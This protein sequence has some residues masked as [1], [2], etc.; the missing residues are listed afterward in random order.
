[1]VT[2]AEKAIKRT[3][4]GIATYRATIENNKFLPAKSH[5][6]RTFIKRLFLFYYIKIKNFY[7]VKH[8]VNNYSL[9]RRIFRLA[10]TQ[11]TSA[12]YRFIMSVNGWDPEE[13]LTEV[14]DES[15]P[16]FIPESEDDSFSTSGPSCEESE[17]E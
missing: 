10:L 8:K 17:P 7:K 12:F 2:I 13:E 3:L 4:I 11:S 5:N 1:M 9:E 6:L 15:D 16:D 14:E